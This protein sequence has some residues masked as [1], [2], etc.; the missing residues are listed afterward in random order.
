MIY[1][2]LLSI[3]MIIYPLLIYPL[4]LRGVAPFFKGIQRR[5]TAAV[6]PFVSIIVI[7]RNGERNIAEKI[8]NCLA[9]DYPKDRLEVI[10]ASDGSEDRTVEIA[11]SFK[12]QEV[13][14]VAAQEHV[15]KI[16]M[17]NRAVPGASGEILVFS[18]VSA[19]LPA[20]T[21]QVLASWFQDLAIGGVCGRKILVE[22]ED[23]FGKVQAHY[24]SYEDS[25]RA[26]ESRI[27]GV[28]SNEG[29]LYA[30]RRE[31]FE[32]LPE[33]VSDDLYNAMVIMKQKRRVLFDP[34]LTARIPVRAK[35]QGQEL[36]R[37]RRIV[38]Q[39]LNGLW[40]MRAL[41]NPL[42]YGSYSWI[43]FSHKVLRRTIPIFL[44]ALLISNFFLIDTHFIFA[45]SF[46]GQVFA[47]VIAGLYMVWSN[48]KIKKHNPAVKILSAWSYFCVGNAGTFIGIVD[49][50]GGKNYSR[51]D[52]VIK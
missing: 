47:Y 23:H 25:I 34:D 12:T 11:E 16:S 51:W 21:V 3:L 36:A 20:N 40:R 41:F 18:D 49:F 50:L 26:C 33:A 31:L 6:L 44:I 9:L 4:I 22:Q 1:I 19:M 32:P 43:L 2:F 38:C 7:V 10:I 15:G 17:M 24:G 13:K 52:S 35:N 14:I 46:Y 8:E 42:E 28:A 29:F 37:R 30:M 27:A 39:S 48:P 5:E 45:M